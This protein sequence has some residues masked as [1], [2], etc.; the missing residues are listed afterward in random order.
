ML[1]LTCCY[2]RVSA[3][4]EWIPVSLFCYTFW[5]LQYSLKPPED[6]GQSFQK[7]KSKAGATFWCWHQMVSG[8]CC[9]LRSFHSYPAHVSTQTWLLRSVFLFLNPRVVNLLPSC[10]K[11]QP[12]LLISFWFSVLPTSLVFRWATHNSF[13]ARYHLSLW[14]QQLGRLTFR[15]HKQLHF[16][17]LLLSNKEN[18]FW[19]FSQPA[20]SSLLLWYTKP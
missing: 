15:G 9:M 13:R 7:L 4:G 12:C 10:T 5:T 16:D 20:P 8:G 19:K 2:Y 11:S 1:I 6:L 3:K 17:S 14:F 18:G